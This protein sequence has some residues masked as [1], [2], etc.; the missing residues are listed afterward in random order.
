MLSRA[1]VPNP[2]QSS[3]QLYARAAYVTLLLSSADKKGVPAGDGGCARHIHVESCPN[4]EKLLFCGVPACWAEALYSQQ[5]PLWGFSALR[6][7]DRRHSVI[8]VFSPLIWWGDR[9]LN[10]SSGT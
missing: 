8:C 7:P 2:G 10:F 4:G 9:I 6:S 1:S 5:A 3:H